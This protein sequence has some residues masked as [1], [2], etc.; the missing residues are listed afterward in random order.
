MKAFYYILFVAVTIAAINF[1]SKLMPS[2]TISEAAEDVDLLI[3]NSRLYAKEHAY[4]RSLHQ[5]D[6]AIKTIQEIEQD[7]DEDSQKTIDKAVREL[8]FVHQEISKHQLKNTDMNHA[9]TKTMNA[10]TYAEL[11]ITEHFIETDDYHEAMAALKSGMIHIENALKFVDGGHKEY[12]LH[13]YAEIDSLLEHPELGKE[14][15][16]KE[17]EKMLGELNTLVED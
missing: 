11:K 1:S 10:L 9:Y 12:E 13:I 6:L 16:V 3:A 15:I 2:N 14:E 17:L 8:E 4:K 5:L 7:L